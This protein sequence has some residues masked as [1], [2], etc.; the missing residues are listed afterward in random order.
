MDDQ[1][2]FLIEEPL[3]RTR[4]RLEVKVKTG[5][6]MIGKEAAQQR[7]RLGQR[8]DIADDNAQLRLF[9][10]RQL[11]RVI[12]Q[13]AELVKKYAGAAV[14]GTSSLRQRHAITGAV[15]Q[16]KAELV[17]Q[18]LDRG[19]NGRMRAPEFRRASL[20]AAFGDDRVEA[21]QLMNGHRVHCRNFPQ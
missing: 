10:H 3:P 21:L 16:P 8:T 5:C 15:E 17:F 13:Q 11:V 20:K 19:E 9:A 2:R 7:Q 4:D 6:W 14:K 18:V 1:I 12:A